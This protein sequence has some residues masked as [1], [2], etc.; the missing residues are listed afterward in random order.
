M[1]M[2][3]TK[4]I[5]MVL[6]V[7]LS[8]TAMA[9]GYKITGR[10]TGNVEGK[11]IYLCK[12]GTDEEMKYRPQAI[13]S[14]V[15]RNG[16]FVFKGK[17]A[18]PSL[19]LLKY[20]PNDNRG[21][22]ENGRIAMRPVL[23]LFM[24][25]EKVNIEANVDDWQEDF[26]TAVYDT[27]DYK[28]TQISGSPLN[29]LY[30][31]YK[32]GRTDYTKRRSKLSE[33]FSEQY[34]NKNNVT[35]VAYIVKELA[36]QDSANAATSAFLKDFIMRN[37]DNLAGVVALDESLS[38]FDNPTIE[39]LVAAISDK[40]KAT[41]LGQNMLKN[42]K[43]IKATARGA[44]FADVTLDDAKGHEHKLSEYLGKGNYTLLEFWASWCGPCRGSIPHLK[45]LYGLYH[46]QGFDIV[47]VSM[48]TDNKAWHKA[49]GEEQMKWTQL[50]CKDGFG[51]VA[52]TYNF[53]GIPYCVL[54]GPKGEIVETNCRD[55]RLDRQMA[56]LYGNKLETFHLTAQLKE[57]TDS[58]TIMPMYYGD[59]QRVGFQKY[60]LK[61][62]K[63]N[64]TLP[65]DKPQALVL[66]R[67][68][69]Y[70]HTASIPALPGE[71]VNLTGSFDEMKIEGSHFYDQY[72]P[73]N[74]KLSKYTAKM[75]ADRVAY[76]T[77]YQ[78]LM[79][80][81]KKNRKQ[82]DANKKAYIDAQEKL[83]AELR[84]EMTDYVK[85]NP[86]NEAVA[87][88]LPY[89][90][91]DS[92]ES[93]VKGLNYYVR[94]GRMKTV[95]D[96]TLKQAENDRKAREAKAAIKPGV[97]APDFTLD[98]INGKPFTLSSLRGKYVVLD[99]W[100]S[101]CGWC[102]KGMP[103]MKKYYEK[104]RGKF[105][106]VGVDCS[107]T[108]EKWKKAVADNQLPWLHVYNKAADGT[109]EKYAVEGYPTKIIINPDG[110][111]NKII[112]GESQEFYKYLDELLK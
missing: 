68:G 13:D 20:F 16:Q 89:V 103:D 7:M 69:D 24:G 17:L 96:A 3:T 108:V 47:S 4:I 87:T 2:K 18:E 56:N 86:R 82:I 10:L 5:M 35:P 50:I 49:L 92:L 1:N 93:V 33:A 99:F 29:D 23:P 97:A 94:N 90:A 66:M 40:M 37:S 25:N 9:K 58:V 100:G 14:T 54:I 105:E 55:A 79:K 91:E 42:A 63:L 65:I 104:Y 26:L 112:V 75:S 102:I 22:E 111:I 59:S 31:E 85:A 6:A 45:Q 60:A 8:A 73:I 57:L 43:T 62:G 15:I 71:F 44:M 81:E 67:P 51:E 70:M 36:R 12:S 64:L 27:Y 95:I 83:L 109:P 80:N 52:K 28:N 78:Q 110:T 84:R 41:S 107:D 101:W 11:T 32:Q 46:P 21:N 74:Q 98:D 38:T 19:L 88:I 30:R 34:Y 61:D 48:D 72:A 39:S 76:E 106:I 53:N 77:Q